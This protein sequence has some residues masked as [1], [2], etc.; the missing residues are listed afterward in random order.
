MLRRPAAILIW[1]PVLGDNVAQRGRRR[2]DLD[3]QVRHA[4]VQGV[5]GDPLGPF[6]ARFALARGATASS[7]RAD[8]L[9]ATFAVPT[10]GLGVATA[11]VP[12]GGIALEGA[13]GVVACASALAVAL[14]VSLWARRVLG[15]RTGD[16]LGA[17]VVVAEIAACVVFLARV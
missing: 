6:V 2:A 14:A 9:G 16:T 10:E 4:E 13:R 5:G 11:I 15:G 1:R 17:A 12:G 7:A 3:G 8:G